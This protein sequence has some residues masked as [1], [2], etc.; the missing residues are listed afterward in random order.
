MLELHVPGVFGRPAGPGSGTCMGCSRPGGKLHQGHLGRL[1]G[2]G[3]TVGVGRREFQ[4]QAS[5][6]LPWQATGACIW[7][8]LSP[9][10]D[11]VASCGRTALAGQ[12]ELQLKYIQAKCWGK[13]VLGPRTIAG[14]GVNCSESLV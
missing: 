14:A 6:E 10:K 3:A 7:S 2:G 1:V 12:L 13:T 5:P 11:P 8:W 9:Q 4:E